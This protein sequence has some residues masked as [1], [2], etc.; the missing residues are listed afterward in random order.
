MPS[1]RPFAGVLCA[2]VLS[3]CGLV[4]RDEDRKDRNESLSLDQPAPWLPQNEPAPS[5]TPISF[6]RPCHEIYDPDLLPT[7]SL[8]IE[9]SE[10]QALNDER[11]LGI[12]NQHPATF[13]YEGEVHSVM[14][15]NRGQMTDCGEKL[16]LAI[17]FNLPDPEHRFRGLRR[18][19]LDHG[20]CHV[21]RERLAFDFAR[22]QVGLKAKCVNNARLE[23]NGEYYGLYSNI[24]HI[25]KDFL[26]RNFD[27]PDGNLYKGS[28]KK[29]HEDDPDTSDWEELRN[30]ASVEEFEA[31]MDLN[32]AVKFLAMEAV[33]P[34]RDNYWCCDRNVYLY[35]HPTDGWFFL[36]HDYDYSFPSAGSELDPVLPARHE[37]VALVL[38]DPEWQ[39]RYKEA[40]AEASAAYDPDGFDARI[41][42][43][44]AQVKSSALQDPF[45]LEERFQDLDEGED[46]FVKEREWLRTRAACIEAWLA[47]EG[48]TE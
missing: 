23:I 27:D 32:E 9:A 13:R 45:L 47:S 11:P 34:A 38:D 16:E 15:R 1:L 39:Q 8:D 35:H 37:H 25:N 21:L 28:H 40:V 29:T 48:L 12:E 24:E 19:N 42:R 30:V 20:N 7:F 44:W 2:A 22:E 6:P 41:D 26:K 46:P 43:W 36:P 18:I 14:V 31:L 4:D 33:L 10:L 5:P 3:G 17:S